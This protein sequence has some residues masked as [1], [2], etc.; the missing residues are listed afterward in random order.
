MV[1]FVLGWVDKPTFMEL[2]EFATLEGK[3]PDGKYSYRID[4]VKLKRTDLSL[5]DIISS[6][7]KVGVSLSQ[8]DIAEIEDELADVIIT[9]KGGNKISIKPNNVF[10]SEL[11]NPELKKAF[12]INYDRSNQEF[13]TYPFYLPKIE[14]ILEKAGYRIKKTL[15]LTHNDIDIEFTG[16]LRDY[17]KEAIDTWKKKGYRGIISLPTGSGKTIIGTAIISDVK[18]PTLIVANRKEQMVQWKESLLNFT[19]IDEK[20]VGL[21]YADEKEIKNITIASYQTAHKHMDELGNKYD[22]LIFDE[23]HHAP[24]DKF[25]LIALGS[26]A[27]K[28]VGLTATPIREDDKVDDL[29]EL[30]GPIVYDMSIDKLIPK[31]Y[32]ADYDIEVIYTELTPDEREEYNKLSREYETHARGRNMSELLKDLRKGEPNAKIAVSSLNRIRELV[33][34]SKNKLPVIG[35]ILKKE[36][37]RKTLI[38]T[39]YVEQGA[40]ISKLYNIDFLNGKTNKKKRADI[41]EKFKKSKDGRL[42]ITTIGDEGLDI[43]DAEVGIFASRTGSRIQYIQSIGR[44]LRPNQGKK[45]KVYEI[46]SKDTP[47]VRWAERRSEYIDQRKRRKYEFRNGF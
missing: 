28:R 32:L 42:I 19:N 13:E 29:F 2:N 16:N 7:S 23:A 33:T 18:K 8:N 20:D 10:I 1:K 27:T 17:Q 6:L 12:L 39:Q 24:A 15:P 4:P 44:L 45:A 35:E 41:L 38:F 5:D 31:N 47:E 21:Y 34:T 30:V 14:K 11:G 9:P 26:Y 3:N 40:E 36:A 43:P 25:K 22:L 46:V 37:G